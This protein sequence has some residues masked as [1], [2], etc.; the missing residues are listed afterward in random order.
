MKQSL[1]LDFFNTLPQNEQISIA[2]EVYSAIV[3]SV[4]PKLGFNQNENLRIIR[5]QLGLSGIDDSIERELAENLAAQQPSLLQT[6][7]E[8]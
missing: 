1:G 3:A 7:G 5:R 8:G 2:K 4:D 6:D